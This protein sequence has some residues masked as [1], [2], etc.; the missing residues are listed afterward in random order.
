MSGVTIVNAAGEAVSQSKFVYD[1]DGIRVR[2]TEQEGVFVLLGDTNLDGTV[3]NDDV[4]SFVQA[5]ENDPSLIDPLTLIA[6]DL[7]EDGLIDF[8]DGLLLGEI[9]SGNA[10][11]TYVAI[12]TPG[13]PTLYVVDK[14][15]PTGYAQTLEEGVDADN[16]GQLDPDEIE[17]TY[18]L[19]HDVIAQAN[20]PATGPGLDPLNLSF[21]PDTWLSFETPGQ[22]DLND[23]GETDATVTGNPSVVSGGI[24][25]DYALRLDGSEPGQG[26]DL[27][28]ASQVGQL[29]LGLW[30]QPEA[31]LVESSLIYIA[32]QAYEITVTVETDTAADEL[33]LR[34][35]VDNGPGGTTHTYTQTIAWTPG[36]W[37]HLGFANNQADIAICPHDD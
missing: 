6:A 20:R 23:S 13:S 4:P 3:N 30:F 16:D 33:T 14:N 29:S 1:N 27:G 19:G 5:V 10:T 32:G 2:K 12:N 28:T 11:P 35:T 21:S 24:V 7:N 15:N 36:Q 25:G 8:D 34:L 22:P 17:K 31:D 18:V 37:V 26:I 9:L